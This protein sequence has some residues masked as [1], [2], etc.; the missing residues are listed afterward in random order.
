MSCDRITDTVAK[1][2]EIFPKGTHVHMH[3]TGAVR[4][5]QLPAPLTDKHERH[6][7]PFVLLDTV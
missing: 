7:P 3:R 6:P 5:P 4:F 1:L 2:I